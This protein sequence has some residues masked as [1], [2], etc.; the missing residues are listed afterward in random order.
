M[1][2]VPLLA[3]I[4][5]SPTP[6]IF[7]PFRLGSSASMRRISR[8]TLPGSHCTPTFGVPVQPYSSR[9]RYIRPSWST[10]YQPTEKGRE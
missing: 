10:P 5:G 7:R 1:L 4:A 8:A 3:Q 6:K 2:S 9:R